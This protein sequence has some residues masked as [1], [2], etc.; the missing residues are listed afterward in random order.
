MLVSDFDFHLPPELIAQQPAAIRGTSRMLQ[1]DRQTGMVHD[2]QFADLPDLLEPGDLLVLNDSRV[3]PARLFA[4]RGGLR[5]QAGSPAPD[6]VVEVLLTEQLGGDPASSHDAQSTWRALVKPAKKV[7][8]DETLFF[9]AE[10]GG[11]PLLTAV[12]IGTAEFGERTLKFAPV[13]DFY[14]SLERIGHLP[15]PPY[16]HRQRA[17]PNTAEDRERY[18]TVYSQP[19]AAGA[20]AVLTGNTKEETPAR[21]GSAAAPTAGLHFTPEVLQRL[22]D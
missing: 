6:G 10:P 3:L 8:I 22:Q 20:G 13:Q 9:A 5:T 7:Q 19:F 18:Q 1:L 4:T 2:R 11:P 16:I 17:Q 12:V 14:A 15:L 21:M